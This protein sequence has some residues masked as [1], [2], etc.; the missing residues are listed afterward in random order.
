MVRETNQGGLART[1]ALPTW[2][3]DKPVPGI[4]FQ[5]RFASPATCVGAE[6]ESLTDSGVQCL[7]SGWAWRLCFV[8]AS[9]LRYASLALVE[10]FRQLMSS[11][12]RRGELLDRALV[13]DD[14]AGSPT[15]LPPPTFDERPN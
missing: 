12:V 10:R 7:S 6:S 11:P 2:A 9:I 3:I 8:P 13:L 5:G 14:L 4:S 15:A 1:V